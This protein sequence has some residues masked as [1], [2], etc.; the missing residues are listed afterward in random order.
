MRFGHLGKCG[1][2]PSQATNLIFGRSNSLKLEAFIRPPKIKVGGGGHT[3]SMQVWPSF[4]PVL[5]WL[6]ARSDPNRSGIWLLTPVMMLTLLLGQT[7]I[8]LDLV[9]GSCWVN[10]DLLPGLCTIFDPSPLF[11]NGVGGC[12]CRLDSHWFHHQSVIQLVYLLISISKLY[13]FVIDHHM[14]EPK[15]RVL[16]LRFLCSEGRWGEI[17]S[18]QC[19]NYFC[20][21]GN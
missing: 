3:G 12:G 18:H 1:M 21:F 10:V 17:P 15:L 8:N 13:I 7:C 14:Y 9:T 2:H 5:T 19:P 20:D 16:E 11:L 4:D 6:W